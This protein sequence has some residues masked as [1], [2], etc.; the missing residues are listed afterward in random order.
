MNYP[1]WKKESENNLTPEERNKL[2][3]D[4]HKLVWYYVHK[5]V[6]QE[7]LKEDAFQE[8]CLGLI[9]AAH[10]YTPE[11]DAKFSVFAAFEIQCSIRD[12][13]FY[14]R[15]IK[16]PD[17]Q[18]KGITAYYR[19]INA[20]EN[21]EIELTPS[22]LYDTAKEFGLTDD[23]AERVTT[24]SLSFQSEV[25][26]ATGDSA[27]YLEDMIASEA[28][29]ADECLENMYSESLVKF[30]IELFESMPEAKNPEVMKVVRTYFAETMRKAMG[31]EDCLTMLETV[32]SLKPELAVLES[33]T[34]EEA[35]T[36]RRLVD[37]LYCNASSFWVKRRKEMRD[38][39]M[40]YIAATV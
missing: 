34:K 2:V 10:L 5:L 32:R 21:E 1:T 40:D 14:N 24:P 38:A 16:L 29:N 19:K 4:N 36:K 11:R 39:I 23:V 18:R 25:Y 8:G 37:N 7:Q 28:G 6:A 33:D 26:G 30:V 22:M 20:L 15:D 3:A 13:L 31:K 12:Y 27:L 17:A 35:D 9:R